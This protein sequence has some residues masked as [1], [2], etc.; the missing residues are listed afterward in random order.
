MTEIQLV[1]NIKKQLLKDINE[2]KN[3]KNVT[4]IQILQKINNNLSFE[5]LKEECSKEGISIDYAINKKYLK[6]SYSEEEL[7]TRWIFELPINN[8]LI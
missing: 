5:I 4:S 6:K 1:K 7:K 8:F 3:N 2:F